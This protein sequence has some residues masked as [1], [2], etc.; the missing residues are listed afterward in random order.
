MKILRI[1]SIGEYNTYI[2]FDGHNGKH[3][4]IMFEFHECKHIPGESDYLIIPDVLLDSHSEAFTQPIALSEDLY[5]PAGRSIENLQIDSQ[6]DIVIAIIRN[7]GYAMK[8]LY[9]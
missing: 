7:T 6:G 2:L 5:A 9:G 3:F 4:E 1:K 8:R